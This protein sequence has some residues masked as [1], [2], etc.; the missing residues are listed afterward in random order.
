MNPI[1][2]DGCMGWLH[3]A[4]G[5]RGVVL[6]NAF[7]HEAMWSHKSMRRL[8]TQLARNG[9]PT[10]RFDYHGTGD[11]A[12]SDEDP[13]RLEMWGG[14]IVAAPRKLGETTGGRGLRA[15]RPRSGAA[16]PAPGGQVLRGD[17]T[18]AGLVLLAPAV[19]GRNYLRE[20]K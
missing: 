8:A 20:L 17:E 3:D 15:A 7:G 13:A 6:C 16:P 1:V 18:P 19:A 11:S 2:F 14:N 10:L 9:M 12:G 4:P 5:T